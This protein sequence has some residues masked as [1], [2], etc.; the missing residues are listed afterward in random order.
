MKAQTSRTPEINLNPGQQVTPVIVKIGGGDVITDS[1]ENNLMNMN[2]SSTMRFNDDSINDGDKWMVSTSTK[3]GRIHELSVQDGNSP[4]TYCKVFPQPDVFTS[5][6]V[7]FA[8]NE[9]LVI[10]EVKP[11][12]TDDTEDGYPLQVQTTVTPFK[13]T[14]PGL[15]G[16]WNASDKHFPSTPVSLVFSQTSSNGDLIFQMEYTFNNTVESFFSLDFH[17][18]KGQ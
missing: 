8:E 4:G 16:G 2:I 15:G 10:S 17:V 11:T 12:P 9:T 7:T 5:L 1:D 14:Q 3:T 6:E 13:I 18:G